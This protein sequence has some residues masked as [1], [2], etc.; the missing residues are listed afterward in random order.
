MPNRRVFTVMVLAAAAAI[1]G[2]GL[3]RAQKASTTVLTTQD[4]ADIQQ[5]YARY[6]Q[7]IDSGDAE[8][9][10]SMFTPD[11]VFNTN[12]RGHD[13]LA[14]FVRD[15]REKRNGANRRHWNSNLVITPTAEGAN[16]SV[17][18]LLLDIGV[19]P[20]V[21][22]LTAIYEDRLVKTAAGWRFKSR[23]VHADPAPAQ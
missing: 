19:R 8:G 7:A 20:A 9:W 23:I 10:A 11:G 22:A 6:N 17:Y 15:W 3:L 2:T 13:A 21:P 4:Y 14:Q 5:L 1:L 18:L 16:G 12:T